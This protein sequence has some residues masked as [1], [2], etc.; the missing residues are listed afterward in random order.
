[1]EDCFESIY[2]QGRKWCISLP[3]FI[4]QNS[5]VHIMALFLTARQSGKQTLTVCPGRRGKHEIWMPGERMVG[6]GPCVGDRLCWQIYPWLHTVWSWLHTHSLHQ[7]L[8][9]RFNLNSFMA[10][11]SLVT[12]SSLQS[13]V[14]ESLALYLSSIFQLRGIFLIYRSVWGEAVCASIFTMSSVISIPLK[15]RKFA[16]FLCFLLI[17]S[18]EALNTVQLFQWEQGK[19]KVNNWEK[20]HQLIFQKHNISSMR[21]ETMSICSP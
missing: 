20:Q 6:I 18:P 4:C 21:A 15:Y 16:F 5:L 8:W 3:H 12:L 17:L 13:A 7:G 19:K 10:P 14:W 2:G 11:S 1:M 9:Q